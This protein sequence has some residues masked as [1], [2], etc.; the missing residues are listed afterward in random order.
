VDEEIKKDV[1]GQ[2][3]TAWAFRDA[4]WSMVIAGIS[5]DPAQAE[6]IRA[7]AKEYWE[8]VHPCTLGG[9]YAKRAAKTIDNCYGYYK[10]Y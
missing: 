5:P 1:L 10:Y 7:W 4:T 8:A 9:A 3:E 6:A 2:S